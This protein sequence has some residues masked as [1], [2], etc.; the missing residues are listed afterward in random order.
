MNRKPIL[1]VAGEPNSI[2]FEI[3]FKAIKSYKFQ[4]PIVLVASH[5]LLKLQMKAFKFN[6]EIKI[7]DQNK[8]GEYKLNNKVLNL[9]EENYNT[10]KAFKKISN[11]S[12]KYIENCFNIAV[13]LIKSGYTNKLINGP[14]SKKNFLKKNFLVSRNILLTSLRLKIL[15]C[16]FTISLYQFVQL[17]HIFPSGL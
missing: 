13:N 15:V 11:D 16:L 14:I 3:F 5:K 8:L 1:I 2:F 9:I 7:L 17:P 6:R 10:N 12:S 4:S